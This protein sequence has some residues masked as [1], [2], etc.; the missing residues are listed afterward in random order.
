MAEDCVSRIVKEK[1]LEV[2]NKCI[3][4]TIGLVGAQGYT[5]NLYVKLIQKYSITESTAIHLANTYGSR[6]WEVCK[7]AKPVDKAWP[8]F[9]RYLVEGYPYIESEVEYAAKHE[10]AQTV[11]DVLS[12][13]T[14]LAFVNSE[15]AKQAAP[16]VA[17][18]MGETLGWSQE[19]QEQQLKDALEYLDSFGGPIPQVQSDS[20][21]TDL[22]AL[23]KQLDYDHSGYLDIIEIG[24]AAKVLGFD[25]A[26]QEELKSLFLRIPG[27]K[28]GKIYKPDFI[29]FWKTNLH[30]EEILQRIHAEL[31]LSVD[32]LEDNATGVMFG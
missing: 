31:K 20:R 11:K 29:E 22:N 17:A 27:G 9:G 28:Q 24:N 26:T 10:Y 8:R 4:K 15:A 13:R 3:T 1:Q 23:F 25:V 5:S 21:F 19:I 7:L 18:I 16:R 14:R 12:L 32:K 6:A 2:K 30:Q